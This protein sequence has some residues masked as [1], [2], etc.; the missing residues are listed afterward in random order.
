MGLL[1]SVFV[2]ILDTPRRR[3]VARYGLAGIFMIGGAVSV[4]FGLFSANHIFGS[5]RN[6]IPEIEWSSAPPGFVIIGSALFMLSAMV[7][8]ANPDTRQTKAKRLIQMIAIVYAVVCLLSLPIGVI[9]WTQMSQE[10]MAQ[11]GYVFVETTSRPSS[12]TTYE[13][14]RKSPSAASPR[15]PQPPHDHR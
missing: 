12:K 13:A 11:R 15:Q 9:V 14:W 4:F 3:M 2:D 10:F 5:A 1:E 8:A 6:N 7:L